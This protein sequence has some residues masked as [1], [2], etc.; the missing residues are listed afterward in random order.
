MLGVVVGDIGFQQGLCYRKTFAELKNV[1][2]E[3]VEVWTYFCL[4]A[5]NSSDLLMQLMNQNYTVDQLALFIASNCYN[6]LACD[7]LSRPQSN[8]SISH[9]A[10]DAVAC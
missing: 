10:H 6:Y 4:S 8:Q 1:L 7:V 3:S 5:Q 2:S 9:T